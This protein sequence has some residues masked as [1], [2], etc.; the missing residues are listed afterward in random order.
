MVSHGPICRPPTSSIVGAST[1]SGAKAAP[2]R[3]RKSSKRAGHWPRQRRSEPNCRDLKEGLLQS[4]ILHGYDGAGRDGLIGFCLHLAERHPKVHGGLLA[5]LLPY[6]LHADV[7]TAVPTITSV[8]I[9]SVPSGVHFSP[10]RWSA[11]SKA[12]HS[13]SIT[14]RCARSLRPSKSRLRYDRR[15]GAAISHV[16]GY[17]CRRA[18]RST[19]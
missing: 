2:Q 14:T 3:D 17:E 1:A 19:E 18:S 11:R 12:S 7:N 10:S 15:R 6:N 9:V 13:R 4:A 8:N 16:E 5:K